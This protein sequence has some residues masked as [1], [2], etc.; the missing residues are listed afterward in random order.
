VADSF[1]GRWLGRV[2]SAPPSADEAR[3]ELDRLAAERPAVRAPALWLRELLPELAADERVTVPPLT[4]DQARAKLLGGV[5]LLRGE[6]LNLDGKALQRR[7][8]RACAALGQHQGD[9]AAHAEA[10]RRGRLDL[11]ELAGVV[12]A[13]NLG[14]VAE[15]SAALG[16][17]AG[18]TATLLR[19]TL[20]PALVALEAALAPLRSG[21][22]WER[23]ECPTCGNG[24]LLGEFRGL[25]QSRH[26]RCGWCAADWP[27]PRLF[28]PFCG[29]RDHERLGFLHR[30]GEEM[31]FRTATCDACRGCVKMVT[32][33]SALS[34]LALLVA[35]VATLHLDLAAA[36]RG[37]GV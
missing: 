12:V 1:L 2:R 27:V 11:V 18:L 26:L 21:V 20:F 16:L 29:C 5:P 4:A 8:R 32:T 3:A 31:R 19:F 14:A 17:D 35:D 25:D 15:R 22:G 10:V 13:G 23:G 37:Y 9:G 30:E 6:P 36:E 24:P 28:C 34:P 7:W 33:L